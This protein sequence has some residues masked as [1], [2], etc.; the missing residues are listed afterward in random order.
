[1]HEAL[2]SFFFPPFG[3]P[4][5]EERSEAASKMKM[6]TNRRSFLPFSPFFFFLFS[7]VAAD[8]LRGEGRGC[9][10]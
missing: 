10:T 3:R 7:L 4:P 8:G 9:C 1:V 5:I 6:E 2:F